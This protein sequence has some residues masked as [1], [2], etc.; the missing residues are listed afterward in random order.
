MKYAKSP[1]MAYCELFPEGKERDPPSPFQD[2][3]MRQGREHETRVISTRYPELEEIPYTDEL[4]G[5]RKALTAMSAGADALHGMPLFWL[6]EGLQGR[7][8]ILERRTTRKSAFGAHHYVVKEVKSARTIREHHILQAA[9]YNHVLGK[10]QGYTP[11]RFYLIDGEGKEREESFKEWKKD[12]LK[13]VGEVRRMAEGKLVPTPTYGAGEWPWKGYADRKAIELKDISLV[14][15]V[16]EATK[17]KLAAGGITTVRQLADAEPATLKGLGARD[18]DRLRQGAAAILTGKAVMLKAPEL[19]SGPAIYMDFEST[20][21]QADVDV[22]KVDYLIGLLICEHGRQEYRPFIAHTPDDEE[23]MFREFLGFMEARKDVPIFH[24]HHYECTRMRRLMEKYGA[25]AALGERILASMVDLHKVATS[26]VVLPTY[27]YGLKEIAKW[28]G[29][30]WRHADVN[31]QESVAMYLDYARDSK[32]H[33][34]NLH[35]IL[36]YNEDDCYATLKVKEY[37]DGLA[38]GRRA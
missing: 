23:R 11:A 3:I 20:T 16:K 30:S 33:A 37:L 5:F 24:W 27:G 13:A 1:F 22:E 32:R 25:K 7:P 28:L 26:C 29:F 31:A 4:D 19:P 35:R 9:M 34:D 38:D 2:M 8:D 14:S 6:P 12:L 36:D 21:E 15:G 10:V 17:R 18:A